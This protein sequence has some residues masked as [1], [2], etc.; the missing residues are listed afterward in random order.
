MVWHC[1]ALCI[2]SKWTAMPDYMYN[3]YN[4]Y[5]IVYCKLGVQ[6]HIPV[7]LLV[8]TISRERLI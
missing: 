6:Q 7:V 2:R 3:I 5:Y 4:Y 1:C 8:S